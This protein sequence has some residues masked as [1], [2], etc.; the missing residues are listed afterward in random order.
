MNIYCDIDGTLT[1]KPD[2]P[3]GNPVYENI[4]AVRAA[5]ANGHTLILWSAQGGAYAREFA[6]RHRIIADA[7]LSKPDV[8]FDD[9]TAIRPAGFM[10]LVMP[11]E[12]CGWVSNHGVPREA[13]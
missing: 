12:M 10:D 13:E 7:Y 4:D 5:A 8:C 3:W 2:G 9:C 11:H 1:D 6:K